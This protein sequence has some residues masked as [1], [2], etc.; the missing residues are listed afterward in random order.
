[1]TRRIWDISERIEPGTATFPGDNAFSQEWVMR[2]SE[3]APCNVSTIRMSVHVGTHTDA[4]LHYDS[5]GSDIAG[6]DLHVYTG[7]CRVLAVTPA[8]SPPQVSAEA[9]AGAALDGVERLL[10]R[11]NPRHDHTTFDPAFASL[12]AAAA[13]VVVDKGVRLVGIDT[14][15]MDHAT[16]KEL[17]G[18]HTLYAG[19]VAI[20]ENLDLT[21]VP[22][23]DYELIA[24]PLRIVGCDSSPVRAILRELP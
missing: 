22:E 5:A 2:M 3:G 11:T 7:R 4:P 9:L 18:H 24:L 14:P 1:M 6:V 12:G 23:G 20:L 17:G 10:L 15:S 13:A 8:G 19:G 16:D 21:D